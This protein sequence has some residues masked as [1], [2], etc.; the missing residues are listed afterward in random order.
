MFIRHAHFAS[1]DCHAYARNDKMVGHPHPNGHSFRA[2]LYTVCATSKTEHEPQGIAQTAPRLWQP[3]Q[4]SFRG[5]KRRGNPLNRNEN[6]VAVATDLACFRNH[7]RATTLHSQN[8]MNKNSNRNSVRVL[9]WCVRLSAGFP[10]LRS[11]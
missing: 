11:E 8:E 7:Y 9:A 4:M 10:R 1:L 5:A 6:T 3:P 2:F